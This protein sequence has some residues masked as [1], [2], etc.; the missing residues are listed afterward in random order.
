MG[1][2][3][4][5]RADN[6]PVLASHPRDLEIMVYCDCPN[7]ASDVQR[8]RCQASFGDFRRKEAG[9][10]LLS[11]SREI[12]LMKNVEAAER[13]ATFSEAFRHRI[14]DKAMARTQ[15]RQNDPNWK[16]KDKWARDS[17]RNSGEQ[18]AVSVVC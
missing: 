7:E 12:R 1:Q 13:F 4:A 9:L 2:T 16:P 18:K 14:R 17:I 15:R 5:V 8:R 10:P 11:V 6:D 3:I